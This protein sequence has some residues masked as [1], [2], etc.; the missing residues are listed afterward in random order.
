VETFA[1]YLGSISLSF[2]I[3]LG[4]SAAR[5]APASADPRFLLGDGS[6]RILSVGP[7][8]IDEDGSAETQLL[9]PAIQRAQFQVAFLGGD[10]NLLKLVDL[11]PPQTPQAGEPFFPASFK[12]TFSQ[13]LLGITDGA[14]NIL[15]SGESRG[16]IAILIGLLV[17]AVQKA[18][19]F[20]STPAASFQLMGPRG[21]T[22][23]FLP[24]IEQS[25]FHH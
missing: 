11:R 6:V 23:A 24:Y 17:P 18:D 4:L 15:F 7:V 12:L 21:E 8:R 14:G 22:I 25:S 19:L 5:P 10:G 16:I 1:R 9:L 20:V 2:V 13:G 3:V